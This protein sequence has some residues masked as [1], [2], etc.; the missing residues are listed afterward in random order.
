[1]WIFQVIDN[2]PPKPSAIS[3][4]LVKEF[5]SCSKDLWKSFSRFFPKHASLT[6][7]KSFKHFT[8]CRSWG[9]SDV[10]ILSSLSR[11][12]R[13][14][15]ELFPSQPRPW[16]PLC[17]TPC[18]FNQVSNPGQRSIIKFPKDETTPII[19]WSSGG[20]TRVWSRV[21]GSS[22]WYNAI[23]VHSWNLHVRF[24]H[25]NQATPSHHRQARFPAWL[26]KPK[27]AFAHFKSCRKFDIL[28]VQFF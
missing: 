19:K 13:I 16:Y 2:F 20:G 5:L 1:M 7:L 27:T 15:L 3:W 21:F 9:A 23:L 11:F 8:I 6:A 26:D 14:L 22:S 4:T 17:R 10:T 28:E 24:P 12:F 25:S 18:S